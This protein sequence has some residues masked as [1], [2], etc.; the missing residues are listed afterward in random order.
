MDLETNGH[1]HDA[2]Y[3]ER[4]NRYVLVATPLQPF[5]EWVTRLDA[6]ESGEPLV[7][8]TLEEAQLHHQATF[9]VP[10]VDEAGDL[11]AWIR[12]NHDL[13][14]DH[15]LHEVEEDMTRW[16]GERTPEMFEAWF[17]LEL[18]DAPVDLVDAP[19]YVGDEG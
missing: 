15:I 7:P 1:G 14:F 12:E 2:P 6:E 13:L 11:V 18:L 9:L 10:Y 5:V 17:D 4:L 8:F 16:P 3:I 19:L